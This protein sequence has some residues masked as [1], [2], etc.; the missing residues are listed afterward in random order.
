MVHSNGS[1]V[2][3]ICIYRCTRSSMRDGDKF[4]AGKDERVGEIGDE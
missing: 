1:I 4:K 3:A 2:G